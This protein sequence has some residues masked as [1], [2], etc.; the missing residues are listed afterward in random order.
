MGSESELRVCPSRRGPV[1]P[2][3]L[4]VH[5]TGATP[6]VKLDPRTSAELKGLRELEKRHA[7]L[8]EEHELL[9]KAIRFASEQRQRSSNSSKQT[10]RST[11]SR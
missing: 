3:M 7:I 5:G 6:Q 8:V 1:I 4:I 2:Q 9:K 10:G 11:K